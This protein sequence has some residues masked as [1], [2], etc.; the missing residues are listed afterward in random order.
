MLLIDSENFWED[1]DD[2]LNE[3]N[4]QFN[5]FAPNHPNVNYDILH[6]NYLLSGLW[7]GLVVLLPLILLIFSITKKIIFIL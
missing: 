4:A 5:N 7:L 3:H 6:I 2:G 1:N